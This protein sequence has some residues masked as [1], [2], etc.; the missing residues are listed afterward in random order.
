MAAS[1]EVDGAD[2]RFHGV[3]QD[4]GLLPPA[5]RILALA[6]RQSR[7]DAQLGRQ[8]GQNAG[9]HHRRPHLG[10][11]ALSQVRER[12]EQVVGH[13]QAEHGVTQELEALVGLGAGRLRAPRPV[14]Q[15]EDEECVVGEPSS[16]AVPE[17]LVGRVLAQDAWARR[18]TT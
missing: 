1:V 18:A 6:Q 10:Q 17:D 16:Q 8:V 3:G 2:D 14:G 13:D 4:R 11:L 5:R 7:A 12:A 15:G 9:V